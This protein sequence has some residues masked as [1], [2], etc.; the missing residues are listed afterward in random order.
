[1]RYLL[2]A[3]VEIGLWLWLKCADSRV[4]FSKGIFVHSVACQLSRE[5]GEE[6]QNLL[7]IKKKLIYM[8]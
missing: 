5:I 7:K 1:M 4:V 3:I 2:N 8:D 6:V